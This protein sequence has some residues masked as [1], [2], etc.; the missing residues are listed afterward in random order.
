V[1]LDYTVKAPVTE[2]YSHRGACS[3]DA[4]ASSDELSFDVPSSSFMED[5]SSSPSVE[6]SS[7]TDSSLEQLVRRSHRLHWP[8]D[9][10]S[11][12]AFTVTALSEPASYRDA[13]LHPE[14]QH[15]MAEENAALKWTHVGSC[16]LSPTCSSDH[17]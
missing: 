13:I 6:P 17:L 15:A 5:V 12:S 8:P 11:P 10:Y 16:A 2:F 7:L 14:W 9:C 1:V 4:P 3:S